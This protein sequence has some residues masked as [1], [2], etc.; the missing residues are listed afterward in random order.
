MLWTVEH[1]KNFAY[2]VSFGVLH[3]PTKCVKA[4]KG[5]KTFSSRLTRWVDRL[6][7][8][9]FSVII[10]PG[11]TLGFHAILLNMKVQP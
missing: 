3:G 11:R 5:N 6:H 8:F 10:E 1:F 2:G 4:N 9:D 7:R